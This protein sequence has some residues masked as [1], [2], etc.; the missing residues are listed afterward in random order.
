MG[1]FKNVF[2]VIVNDG[3]RF[4]SPNQKDN[5]GIYIV[6]EDAYNDFHREDYNSTTYSRNDLIF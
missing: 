4:D 1:F 2:K 3:Y 5:G 6:G